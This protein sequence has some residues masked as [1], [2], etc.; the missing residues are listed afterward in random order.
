MNSKPGGWLE[1]FDVSISV[2]VVA[3]VAAIITT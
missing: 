3:V 1:A 2:T